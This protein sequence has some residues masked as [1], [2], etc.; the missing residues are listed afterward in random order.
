MENKDLKLIDDSREYILP[1]ECEQSNQ[2]LEEIS[3]ETVRAHYAFI[4]LLVIAVIML[5][6]AVTFIVL[7]GEDKSDVTEN[8]LTLKTFW[9][10]KFS[11]NIQKSYIKDLPFSY[12]LKNAQSRISFLYGIG[13]HVDTFKKNKEIILVSDE[14]IEHE[15]QQV[16]ENFEKALTDDVKSTEKTEKT[17]AKKKSETK[18]KETDDSLETTASRRTTEHS[19]TVTSQ[20]TTSL[21]TT[22]NNAPDV[23][24][25]ETDPPAD[26]DGEDF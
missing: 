7:T 16:K 2:V 18:K 4:N 25:I 13:N 11:E 8:P 5:A 26:D 23:I 14:D 12:E 20:Q 17:T 3:D 24:I 15:K 10:G 1:D 9:S 19:K 22:N 6:A 21:T